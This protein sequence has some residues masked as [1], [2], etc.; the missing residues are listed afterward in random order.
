MNKPELIETLK[1]I[2]RTKIFQNY[3]PDY[4]RGYFLFD[5]SIDCNNY[6]FT[7]YSNEE[8]VKNQ[9][10]FRFDFKAFDPFISTDSLEFFVRSEITAT[11]EEAYESLAGK[12]LSINSVF[13]PVVMNKILEAV[14]Y[15]AYRDKIEE[16]K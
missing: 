3:I 8:W 11:R 10:F 4:E 16:I 15:A 12:I 13:T 1:Q 7:D 5:N 9:L 6:I 2:K 14:K